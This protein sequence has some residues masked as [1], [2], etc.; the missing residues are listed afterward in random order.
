MAPK[1]RVDLTLAKKKKQNC[2]SSLFYAEIA[3]QVGG[4]VTTSAV[5][6]FY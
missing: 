5:Q 2:E 4:T 3:R 1:K 6:K